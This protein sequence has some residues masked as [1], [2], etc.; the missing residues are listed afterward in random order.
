MLT[1]RRKVGQ[2]IY[3]GD[4]PL[5]LINIKPETIRISFRNTDFFLIRGIRYNLS[6]HTQIIFDCIHDAGVR[7]KLHSPLPIKRA[8]IYKRHL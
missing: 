7:I 2:I 8:E 6:P 5:T 1:L 3:I 4:E